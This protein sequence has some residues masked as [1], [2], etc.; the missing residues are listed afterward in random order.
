M[1]CEDLSP[2]NIFRH[3]KKDEKLMHSVDWIY[4]P[5]DDWNIVI[6]QGLSFV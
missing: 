5:I 6:G 2:L 1:T 3:V 4:R